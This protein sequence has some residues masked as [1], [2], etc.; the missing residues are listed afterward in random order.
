M[1]GI[2]IA[3][4]LRGI[5]ILAGAALI[6]R[7]TWVFYIFGAFLVY[8][9]INLVRHRG[10]EED[11]EENAFIRRMRKILPITAG[12]P[13]RQDPDHRERQEVL[14]ADDRRVPGARARPT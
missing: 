8:T 10:E 1:V 14:D 4:V 5:F 3:L 13:R 11:Y 7:F 6:E 12:L 9:A 2:I